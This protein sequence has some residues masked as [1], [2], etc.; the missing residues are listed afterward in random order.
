MSGRGGGPGPGRV[1]AGSRPPWVGL[2]AAVWVQVAA[3]SAYVFPLYSHAIKEALGYNQQ[4]LTMLGVG[5]DVGENVGLVP[6]VLANRLP[7]WLILVIGSACAFFGFG[8]LWLVVTKTVAM[9]YWVAVTYL[10][11]SIMILL[12]L[13]PLVIPIKMTLYPNKQTKENS[14]TLAPSYSSDSLSGADPENSQPLL[15]S[16]STTLATGTN[17]S[18]D[19]TDLDV[20][21][22]E[23]VTVLNNLAQIGMSVGANDTTILLCLFGFCNFAGRIF[24]GS[25]SEYFVSKLYDDSNGNFLGLVEMLAEFDPIIQEHVRR[26]TNEETQ[27]SDTDNDQAKGLANNELGQ[28]EFIV[29]VVIWY[30]VLYAVNLVSKQ[31]QAKDMLIDVAIE[32]VQGLLSFFEGYWETGFLEALESAKKIALEMDIDTTFP[33]KDKLKERDITMK[34]QKTQILP[35]CLERTYFE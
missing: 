30:E 6:G 17:E 28:Y 12:L 31:M 7:P 5:N 21:L 9:P 35:Q 18:D 29:A 1:K 3:G 13:A 11:F 25:V 10:L 8:T 33:K 20:L 27:V 19:S 23:G 26:I 24:G 14:S 34:T 15:G 32:K 4:A 16:A 22:A 2:A